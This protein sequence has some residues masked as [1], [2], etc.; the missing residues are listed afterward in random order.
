[1]TQARRVLVI[2][3]PGRPAALQMAQRCAEAFL[4]AGFEVRSVAGE[5]VDLHAEAEVV[6]EDGAG[7]GCELVIVF[8]G[9]GS[10]L[11]GAE[12]AR[13]ADVP[14]LGVNL[15]KVGFLAELEQEEAHDIAERVSAR[16]YT[17]QHRM[18]LDVEVLRDSTVV[19][20]TWALNEASVE[21]A[22]RQRMISVI[23]EV[24]G[25]PLSRWA[26][27]GVLLATPTGSTGYAWSAGGPVIWPTVEAMMLIPISAHALY[28]RAMVVSDTSRLAVELPPDTEPA[29]MW[30]DGRRMVALQPGDRVEVRRGHRPVHLARLH[31]SLFVDRLVAKFQLPVQGWSGRGGDGT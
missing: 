26:C 13:A 22:S 24:D 14:L 10:I 6:A 9:D 12:L 21:K 19:H 5:A 16:D 30:C 4:A 28:A 23:A 8:G 31:D 27:D 18:T 1:M 11:R 3:H 2:V 29:V 25:R 17:I 15:G 7:V 20:R